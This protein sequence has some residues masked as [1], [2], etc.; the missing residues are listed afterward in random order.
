MGEA[1]VSSIQATSDLLFIV[2][3]INVVRSYHSLRTVRKMI[4]NQNHM[5]YDNK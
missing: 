3:Y 5:C 4:Y 2:I 1:T